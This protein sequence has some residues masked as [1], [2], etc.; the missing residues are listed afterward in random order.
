MSGNGQDKGGFANSEAVLIIPA[1]NEEENLSSV[2]DTAMC[3]PLLNRVIV[4]DD[5]SKG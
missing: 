5:G 3:S 2:L 4:I 1:Y